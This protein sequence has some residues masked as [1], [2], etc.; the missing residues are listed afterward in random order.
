MGIFYFLVLLSLN[1][2]AFRE[3]VFNVEIEFLR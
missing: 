2:G 1:Q 3:R